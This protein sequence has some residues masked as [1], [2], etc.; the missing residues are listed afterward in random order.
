MSVHMGFFLHH[1]LNEEI[2]IFLKQIIMKSQ[3][4]KQD[5]LTIFLGLSHKKNKRSKV[6]IC[7]LTTAKR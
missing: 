7:D 6:R 2:R 4:N 5:E 3:K 1:K